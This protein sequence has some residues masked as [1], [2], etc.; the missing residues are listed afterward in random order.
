MQIDW[1]YNLFLVKL[2][3]QGLLVSVFM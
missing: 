1:F 3:F 2:W